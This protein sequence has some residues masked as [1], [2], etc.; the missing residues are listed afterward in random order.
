MIILVQ[1][2][3][4]KYLYEPINNNILQLFFKFWYHNYSIFKKEKVNATFVHNNN[5]QDCKKVRFP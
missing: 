1:V 5:S 2:T 4:F 3:F